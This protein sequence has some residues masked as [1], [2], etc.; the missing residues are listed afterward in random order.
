MSA[1]IILPP[2]AEPPTS[3]SLRLRVLAYMNGAPQSEELRR[4]AGRK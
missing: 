1:K 4:K 3:E 2:I